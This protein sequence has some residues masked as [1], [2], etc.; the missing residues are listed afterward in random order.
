MNGPTDTTQQPA[1]NAR[2]EA[3]A[4]ITQETDAANPSAEQQQ[5]A[6]AQQ[7]QVSQAEASAKQWG[8]LM[9]TIGGFA[10][11]IAPE[12][13][14]VYSEER[15][16][17]WGQQANAVGEKYGWNGPSSMPELALIASTAGF[18]VPTWLIIKQKVQHAKAAKDGSIVEKLA[19]WWQSR[20]TRR[21]G[22]PADQAEEGAP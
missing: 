4:S 16:F 21:A 20:K 2:L 12:L 18:F 1:P 6:A 19:A 5:Q 14:P 22:P 13:K 3:L 17:A 8:M 10:Q 11:M 9:F 15:C 7:A